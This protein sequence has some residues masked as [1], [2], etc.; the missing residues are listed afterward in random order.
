[1]NDFHLHCHVAAGLIEVSTG[2]SCVFTAICSSM[3]LSGSSNKAGCVAELE[4]FMQ[5]EQKWLILSTKT[6]LNAIRSRMTLKANALVVL[7]KE[8]YQT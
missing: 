2:S 8:I 5:V 7:T 6:L 3:I 1:M 4:D